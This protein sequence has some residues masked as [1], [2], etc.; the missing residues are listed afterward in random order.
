MDR[1]SLWLAVTDFY[2][3]DLEDVVYGADSADADRRFRV[4]QMLPDTATVVVQRIG[5]A[6]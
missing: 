1:L 3:A 2:G 6:L 4:R 5:Q